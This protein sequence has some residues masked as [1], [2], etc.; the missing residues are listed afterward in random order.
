VIAD[1][2]E[3]TAKAGKAATDQLSALGKESSG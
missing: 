2:L 1:F 3:R